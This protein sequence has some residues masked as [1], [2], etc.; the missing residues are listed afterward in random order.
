M[1]L[2][3]IPDWA[4]SVRDNALQYGIGAIGYVPVPCPE[5]AGMVTFG[6]PDAPG[7]L[8]RACF[9]AFTGL[10][11][12][13]ASV[14]ERDRSERYRRESDA[15]LQSLVGGN[16][17][18]VILDAGG[19]YK[20][21]GPT[22]QTLTGYSL[23]TL[24]SSDRARPIHPDDLRVVRQ[25]MRASLSV[26]GEPL[27]VAFRMRYAD[28]SDHHVVATVT[29]LLEADGIEG[30]VF[31]ARD[32]TEQREARV[33]LEHA[34]SHDELTDV[35]NRATLSTRLQEWLDGERIPVGIVFLDLDHFKRVNDS[36]GH[37]VGDQ[38]LVEIANRL[39][40][41]LGSTGLVAG[42]RATSSSCSP[43][44]SVT[45]PRS[46]GSARSSARAVARPTGHRA[47]A[48]AHHRERRRH[49]G[50]SR[51]P[52][53]GTVAR[54]RHRAL[55]GE[56]PGPQPTRAVRLAVARPCRRARWS[57]R[58]HSSRRSPATRWPCTTSRSSGS[59]RRRIVG[60]E[61]LARWT[62]PELGVMDPTDFIAVAEDIGI[63]HEVDT[64]VLDHAAAVAT[65]WFRRFGITVAVNLS[66]QTL[67]RPDLARAVMRILDRH[68]TPA[69]AICIEVTET[70][71]AQ[72]PQT[73]IDALQSL[74]M[75]GMRI[76]IDDFGTGYS[77]IE[78]VRRFPVD[79]IKI[80]RTLIDAIPESQRD[81]AIVR[82]ISDLA[83]ALDLSLTAEGVTRSEQHG[84]LH[85][86]GLRHGPGLPLRTRDE[87]RTPRGRAAGAGPDARGGSGRRSGAGP[88]SDRTHARLSGSRLPGS[89]IPEVPGP[90][91]PGFP[92]AGF[93][94]A[95]F[96][97]GG[98][99]APL[100]SGRRAHRTRGKRM[101]RRAGRKTPF[102]GSGRA[103]VSLVLRV[104]TTIP[105]A[106]WERKGTR[107][108][109]SLRISSVGLEARPSGYRDGARRPKPAGDHPEGGTGCPRPQTCPES[110]PRRTR[111]SRRRCRP[112]PRASSAPATGSGSC[113][114]TGRPGSTR[115]RPGCSR[116]S[117]SRTR[118][119]TPA[120]RSG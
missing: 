20:W 98:E 107:P 54:H 89:Q 60:V 46:A 4:T 15:K 8:D 84:A 94:S 22:V 11:T 12:L 7:P 40:H 61:A 28:G 97:S 105:S 116:A 115:T 52:T 88:A 35:A 65:N 58:P 43:P 106:P 44:A 13:L 10:G 78:R 30:I 90:R 112:C 33:A 34:A 67:S 26:P 119:A 100:G 85:A 77:S 113:S 70:S 62:H 71:Y 120:P 16:D 48:D 81:L 109:I 5:R 118:S 29:N 92:S 56:A 27:P 49:P 117:S 23:E 6:F 102:T 101:A 66:T 82:A 74:R 72:A 51:R 75:R 95:G 93:P 3:E 2:D 19:E 96:P 24:M 76:A 104:G 69:A 57:S 73:T 55:R 41:A 110:I 47:G 108:Q 36:F 39:V 83:H 87:R 80:D 9:E 1:S 111:G 45:M 31:N 14:L 114:P 38:V 99:P 25:T 103:V 79:T 37:T 32:V 91:V 59:V 86:L 21:I 50:P 42:S 53:R 18:V 68:R 17:I 63:V 64:W